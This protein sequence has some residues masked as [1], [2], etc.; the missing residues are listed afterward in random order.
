MSP[1]ASISSSSSPI[2]PAVCSVLRSWS[3]ST[4]ILAN[5]TIR[6][7]FRFGSA[8]VD[9]AYHQVTTAHLWSYSYFRLRLCL[10]VI[11]VGLKKRRGEIKNVRMGL[12][13]HRRGHKQAGG[14]VWLKMY[15][16]IE[17]A[18][19]LTHQWD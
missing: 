17:N 5:A 4:E 1:R 10:P 11:T 2:D 19:G 3:A 16:G 9:F 8:L 7:H 14:W 18:Q 13:T 6:S 12:K 15:G